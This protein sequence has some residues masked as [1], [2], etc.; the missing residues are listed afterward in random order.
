MNLETYITKNYRHK[1]DQAIATTLRT[2]PGK[3]AMIRRHL[4]LNRE[5]KGM[6]DLRTTTEAERKAW[7]KGTF[8]PHETE[9]YLS[10]LT[11]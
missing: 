11:K 3:I 4:G 10:G 1:S 5:P 7:Y 9:W 2:T 8:N 6:R